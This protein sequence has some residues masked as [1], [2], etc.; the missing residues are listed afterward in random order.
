MTGAVNPTDELE[1]ALEQL[2]GRRARL[3]ALA[4]HYDQMQGNRAVRLRTLWHVMRS[5]IPIPLRRP[6]VVLAYEGVGLFPASVVAEP[7]SGSAPDDPLAIY[8]DPDYYLAR[9]PDVIG[10][11]TTPFEH[12]QHWGAIENRPAHPLFDPHWYARRYREAAAFPGGAIRHYLAA[13]WRE[14]FD[15]HPAFQARAYAAATGCAGDALAHYLASGSVGPDPHPLFDG[16]RYQLLRGKTLL[17]P[18]ADLLADPWTEI[19]PHPLFDSTL[20]RTHS[21]DVVAAGVH[22]LAHFLSDGSAEGRAPNHWFD[23]AWYRATY[24]DVEGAALEPLTH[25]A[26]HG[27]REGRNPSPA[28]ATAW[29]GQMNLPTRPDVNPLVWHIET[30]QFSQ[31]P[32]TQL[33]VTGACAAVSV[34]VSSSTPARHVDVVIPVYRGLAVTQRCIESVLGSNLPNETRVVVIDDA[35]P[36][37]L[38]STY[39]TTLGSDRVTVLRNDRN[40][41]FVGT[42]NRAFRQTAG[43]DVVLV[44]SDTVVAGD[45]LLKLRHRA[46]AVRAATVTPFSNNATICS[47]P[48]IGRSN[49]CDA[50]D[51]PRLDAAAAAANAGRFVD[52]PTGVGFCMYVR[53]DALD[54][55]GI[56]DEVRF[57]RGYGEE[58]DFC[59]RAAKAGWRNVLAPDTFVYHEGEASFGTTSIPSKA[60]ADVIVRALHPEY[61]DLVRTHVA[62]DPAHDAR[63]ALAIEAV[64]QRELP[65]ILF[66]THALGGGVATHVRALTANLR[67]RATV[68]RLSPG[69][70]ATVRLDAD[71]WPYLPTLEFATGDQE[72]ELIEVLRAFGVIR[73]HVHSLVGFRLDVAELLRDL[74]IPFD[75]TIHDY[76]TVCPQV[77]MSDAQGVYCGEPEESG[78]AACISLRPPSPLVDI[79]TWRDDHGWLLREAARV[80]APS[81]DTGDRMHRYHPDVEI[82]VVPHQL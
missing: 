9:N 39:L 43:R 76:Y 38:V 79:T 60:R 14:R 36:E 42:V 75:F 29:Y 55:I 33:A 30:G 63:V 56:F 47:F 21:P 19:D 70:G 35:S 49:P 27:W 66:V 81:K 16:A 72:R 23:P 65:V 1:R 50:H 37:P 51:V 68:L 3:E 26:V 7:S 82:V 28:F 48:E 41:G 71:V 62:A 53:R 69:A 5:L 54:E 44:N 73:A 6:R 57:Q 77:T 8:F 17:A 74:D 80:I 15:P 2:E 18:L 40:L 46:Y 24:P 31:L 13:G 78:C 64:K 59:R 67:D 58:V 45:W 32:T 12:Y 52:L 25:F 4:A 22:P 10:S 61:D 20:Y 34:P 11:G